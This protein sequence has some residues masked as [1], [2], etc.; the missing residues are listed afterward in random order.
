[1]ASGKGGGGGSGASKATSGTSCG[2]LRNSVIHNNAIMMRSSI[3]SQNSSG[4]VETS[5]ISEEVPFNGDSGSVETVIEVSSYQEPCVS[6]DE[7]GSADEAERGRQEKI[8]RLVASL[9]LFDGERLSLFV[10]F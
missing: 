6:D 1:M 3:V 7:G 4:K 10:C 8:A 9:S 2:G 5:V